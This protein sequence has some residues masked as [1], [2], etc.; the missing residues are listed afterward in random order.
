MT[1]LYETVELTKKYIEQL[2]RDGITEVIVSEKSKSKIKKS[3]ENKNSIAT[4]LLKL[5]QQV[6]VCRECPLYKTRKNAV[7]GEGN[8]HAKLMFVGEGPGF[9]EDRLGRPFVGR[10]GEL[11][12]K[13]ITEPRA[14]ALKREDVYIANIVKCHPMIDPSQPDKRG[15]DRKPQ[16]DEINA[17]LPYLKK[18]IELI[19]PKIICA[20]GSVSA[21]TLTGTEAPL[22]RLRGRFYDYQGCAADIKV[23]ATYH[24]AALLRN[25]HW[26]KDTWEDIKEIKKEL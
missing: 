4:E 13:I 10:A 20:L 15:N 7:F 25:P 8:P 1:N 5:A 6:S 17:C 3:V 23:I 16:P 14:L 2:R 22:G 11:L 19:K 9:D 18:Q 26:K 24:P 21:T 12:D